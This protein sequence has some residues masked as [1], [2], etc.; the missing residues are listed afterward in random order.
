MGSRVGR[1]AGQWLGDSRVGR[2][3]LRSLDVRKYI[4]VF[5]VTS[6]SSRRLVLFRIVSP[7]FVAG[8]NNM[9]VLQGARTRYKQTHK[10]NIT[11]RCDIAGTP[12]SLPIL[13]GYGHGI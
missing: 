3:E 6:Y 5:N 10:L 7:S 8:S 12:P 13:G 1:F 2:L 9:R 11:L 4:C